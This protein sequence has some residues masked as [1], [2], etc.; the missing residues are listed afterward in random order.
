MTKRLVAT[1]L[2]VGLLI[3]LLIR[4]GIEQAN[5]NRFDH[6]MGVILTAMKDEIIRAEGGGVALDSFVTQLPGWQQQLET[7][8]PPTNSGYRANLL[9]SV[10]QFTVE[11]GKMADTQPDQA[12]TAEMVE[13]LTQAIAGWD[14]QL[15]NGPGEA[16]HSH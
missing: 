12:R 6:D 3:V 4:T 10:L 5:L 16:G 14:E 7:I 15:R 13:N 8:P 2:V 1:G 9:Q 11:Y